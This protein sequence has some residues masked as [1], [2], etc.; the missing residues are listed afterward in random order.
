MKN[1]QIHFNPLSTYSLSL[2]GHLVL[3]VIQHDDLKVTN[4]MT[5]QNSPVQPVGDYR[6]TRNTPSHFGLVGNLAQSPALLVTQSHSL[7]LFR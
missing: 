7:N 5:E 3:L 2:N 6:E 4:K 1:S